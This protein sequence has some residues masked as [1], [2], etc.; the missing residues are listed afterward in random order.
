MARSVEH[1]DKMAE[2][3]CPAKIAP[4]CRNRVFDKML[5]FY[6]ADMQIDVQRRDESISQQHQLELEGPPEETTP[7]QSRRRSTT[8]D[9]HIRPIRPPLPDGERRFASR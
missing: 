3:L 7:A 2:S 4:L 5:L 8:T 6:A 9:V 1:T